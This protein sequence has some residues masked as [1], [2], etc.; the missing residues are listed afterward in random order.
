MSDLK[1]GD[2]RQ[3]VYGEYPIVTILYINEKT[4][5]YRY[6][7][8]DD[9]ITNLQYF[10]SKTEPYTEPVKEVDLA[11]HQCDVG[12]IL[13]SVVGTSDCNIRDKLTC[14]YTRIT[15]KK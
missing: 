11:Y 8:G 2:V 12:N 1:V 7:N 3:W 6:K 15:I 9:C 14:T 4:V 13:V 10:L 5:V